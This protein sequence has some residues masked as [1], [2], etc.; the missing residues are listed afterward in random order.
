MLNFA[1]YCCNCEI[2]V[3]LILVLLRLS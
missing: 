1:T 3:K 2:I